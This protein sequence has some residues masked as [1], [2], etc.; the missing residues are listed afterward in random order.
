MYLAKALA[1]HGCV[2]EVIIVGVQVRLLIG[3][4]E[5]KEER[6]VSTQLWLLWFYT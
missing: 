4:L 2:G 6:T 3:F 1:M 5:R